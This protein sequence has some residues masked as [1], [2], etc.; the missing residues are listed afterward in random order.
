MVIHSSQVCNRSVVVGL[1]AV[2]EAVRLVVDSRCVKR[3]RE[4][5]KKKTQQN[6]KHIH[7]QTIAKQR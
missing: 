1:A 2:R 3:E 7:T 4:R 5:K 6:K